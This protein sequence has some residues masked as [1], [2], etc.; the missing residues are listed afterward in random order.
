MGNPSNL[1]GSLL[2]TGLVANKP[3]APEAQGACYYYA[4]DTGVLYFW[5]GTAWNAAPNVAT[6]SLLTTS[7]TAPAT[8][9]VY[10]LDAV[11]GLS[12][13]LPVATGSGI[14]IEVAVNATLTSG[15][16][17]IL[18]DGTSILYGNA[19]GFYAATG[20]CLGFK[21][22]IATGNYSVA[23]AFTTAVMGNIG[24]HFEFTDVAAPKWLVRGNYSSVGTAA[25]TPF[26]TSKS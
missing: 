7:A 8:N 26:S 2:Q 10:L 21:S 23:L 25:T 11:A 22:L 3:A 16:Y 12:L 4:T 15:A 17:K 24:D 9:G 14:K 20:A 19:V 1:W 18:S 6:P 13:T 5:T